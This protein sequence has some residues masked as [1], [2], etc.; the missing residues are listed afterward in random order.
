VADS[1]GHPHGDHEHG[2]SVYE[3]REFLDAP[4]TELIPEAE[5]SLSKRFLNWRTIASIVFGVAILVFLFAFVLKVD[6]E[7]MWSHITGANPMLLLM[8]LLAYYATFPLRGLRWW[9]VLGKVGTPVPYGAATAMLFLSW[10]VNCLVPAKLGDLY[11]A[12]LLRGNFGGS[13]SRTV[14]TIF[15]ERIADV[16]VIATLALAAGF[17]SFKGRNR[18]EVDTIF[19]LGIIAAI[20]LIGF[21]IALRFA[22]H[23]LTRFLPKRFA[24]LWERFHEGSTA[25]LTARSVPVI[26]GITVVIWLLEG[27]RVYFVIRALGLPEVSNLGI[28]SSVFVALAAALVTAIPLTPAGVGF[29]ELAIAGVLLI[30]GVPNEPA[31]AVALTDR[32]ISIVTVII[33]GGIYYAT[34][35]LVRRA[36][37]AAGR[38]TAV[39]SGAPP[40]G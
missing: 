4:P 33:L 27:A 26:I 16:I 23:R 10:F 24:S 32:A 20:A 36:H 14:G 37:S 25:A 30:Y 5:V 17:W 22:G 13:T 12:F 31:T 28:S 6:W 39:P 8:A 9:F 34:S 29:V 35:P 3:P 7:V 21:V 40:S 15:I 2:H 18:P 1:Q 19:L 38:A 11:R